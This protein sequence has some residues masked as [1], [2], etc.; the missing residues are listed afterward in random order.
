M[1]HDIQAALSF[2][3]YRALRDRLRSG[4]IRWNYARMVRRIKEEDERVFEGAIVG[5]ETV[6]HTLVGETP[7]IVE[8]SMDGV[9]GL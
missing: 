1:G 4:G 9:S 8:V 3:E 5:K 2:W 7:P 6:E